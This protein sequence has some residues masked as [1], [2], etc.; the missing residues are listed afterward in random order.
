[1]G[2]D[3]FLW[4]KYWFVN[5]SKFNLSHWSPRISW[6]SPR[7]IWG[8]LENCWRIT[9]NNRELLKNHWEL[10]KNHLRI[11]RE[12]LNNHQ[13]LLENH[14]RMVWESPRID[15]NH[16]KTRRSYLFNGTWPNDT[17]ALRSF[18]WFSLI[19]RI[20]FIFPLGQNH[21]RCRQ[22]LWKL[23]VFLF[24]SSFQFSICLKK[25]SH[26]PFFV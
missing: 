9:R 2:H 26:Y 4:N 11:V 3:L 8:S 15:E 10:F 25:Y 19:L 22:Q 24:S 20:L 14:L 21:R 7:I 16:I 12:S 5:R 1:M 23:C 17:H 18:Y 13:E 6:Q